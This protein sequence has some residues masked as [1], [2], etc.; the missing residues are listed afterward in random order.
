MRQGR[1]PH[2][3]TIVAHGRLVSIVARVV[4]RESLQTTRISKEWRYI[5][6]DCSK[7]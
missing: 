2:F 1:N 5:P 4:Y 3:H 6:F 7:G